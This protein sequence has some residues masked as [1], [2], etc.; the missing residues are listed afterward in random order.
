MESFCAA[1]EV[2]KYDDGSRSV[3]EVTGGRR[4]R[5]FERRLQKRGSVQIKGERK[6]RKERGE[7]KGEVR[8]DRKWTNR[9]ERQAGKRGASEPS[10]NGASLGP[11]IQ[12]ASFRSTHRR[13]SRQR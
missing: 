10:L 12:A 4:K 5:V 1:P 11:S 3:S 7:G 2:E 9:A 6:E 8:C 13:L